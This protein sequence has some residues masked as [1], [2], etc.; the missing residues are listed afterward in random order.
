MKILIT[1]GCGFIGKALTRQLLHEKHNV[2]VIDNSPNIIL[3]SDKCNYIFTD[4]CNKNDNII[5]TEI[6]RNDLI[7]H[8]AS[9]VG[10]LK[11]DKN[12]DTFLNEMVQ[13]NINIFN[14]VKKYNK[15]IIFS[16]TSEVYFNSINAKETD[17]LVIGSP[18]KARWGYASGKLTSEFLCKSLCKN[19]IILRFFNATGVGDN[20]GVLYQFINSIKNNK[21]IQ[22]YGNGE[23]VRSLCDIRDVVKFI[24][25]IITKQYKGEIYNVGNDNNVI[26][27]NNLAKL[28]LSI[29][30]SNNS[31]I[32]NKY[33][34]I[35]S[36]NYDDII[37]RI[38][39]C[40]KMKKIITSQYTNKNIIK[41]MLNE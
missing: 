10:V 41:S 13:M 35:F 29:S 18:D 34:E 7:I 3:N 8:L 22:I 23:Q 30:K 19:S 5:E 9:P 37:T 27:I 16:S 20:K 15:K 32:Y 1:G 25:T 28:C 6:Q 38:P 11:I 14:L 21:D 4:L 40:D 12:A 39:N 33:K 2:T 26:T 36:N 24:S 17:N 31:I